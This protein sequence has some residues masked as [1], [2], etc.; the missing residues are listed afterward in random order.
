M[1]GFNLG[2]NQRNFNGSRPTSTAA[3]NMGATRGIGS[4]T[5]MFNFCKTHSTNPSGC[6]NQFINVKPSVSVSGPSVSGPSVSGPSVSGPSVSGPSPHTLGVSSSSPDYYT[7]SGSG[8][9]TQ[10]L[11]MSLNIQNVKFITI[12]GSYKT[13]DSSAFEGLLQLTSVTITGTSLININNSAFTLC[14]GLT[15]ITIPNSV[16]N[17]GDIAFYGCTNLKSITIP[18]SVTYIA[19]DAFLS[20]GLETVT[21][22]DGRLGKPSPALGVPFFGV[23]VDTILPPP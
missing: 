11:V 10:S 4:T 20:S 18:N 12:A 16:K 14:I 21:I 3:V 17:I 13:I 15:S 6:I 23:T 9:I 5:R 8:V 22:A 2:F 19:G 1:P 7:F